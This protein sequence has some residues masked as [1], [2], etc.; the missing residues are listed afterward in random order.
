MSQNTTIGPKKYAVPPA[1]VAETAFPPWLNASFRPM[2]LENIF[3][4]TMPSVIA[5]S[6]GGKIAPAMPARDCVATT[7]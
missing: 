7:A 2:R 4:P 5:A 6:A 3:G 1:I